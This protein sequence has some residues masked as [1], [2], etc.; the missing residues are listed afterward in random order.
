MQSR[1]RYSSLELQPRIHT[2]DESMPLATHVG[3]KIRNG[4]NTN[5]RTIV[6]D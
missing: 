2:P 4:F 6:T 5:H 3:A 1:L